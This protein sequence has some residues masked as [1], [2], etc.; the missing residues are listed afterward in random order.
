MVFASV[1][2]VS[3]F[4]TFFYLLSARGGICARGNLVCLPRC[5]DVTIHVLSA[6]IIIVMFPQIGH[7]RKLLYL[8]LFLELLA[9]SFRNILLCGVSKVAEAS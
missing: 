9:R 2:S 8:K 4:G 5:R 7:R 1:L 3:V 6:A